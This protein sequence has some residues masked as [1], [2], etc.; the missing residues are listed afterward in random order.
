MG[1]S[2]DAKPRPHRR[3]PFRSSLWAVAAVLLLIAF[4]GVIGGTLL[5]YA[6]AAGAMFLFVL[7]LRE[8]L[9]RREV[10][11]NF[12]RQYGPTGKDLLVVYSDSPHWKEYI[13]TNW[14]PRWSARMVVLNR[15]KPWSDDQVEVKLWRQEAG[16]LEHTP[17]AILVPPKGS[18]TIVRFWLA[19]R[20]YKHGKDARLRDAEQRLR[21]ALG[22]Y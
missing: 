10:T 13:E 15:S 2:S 14:M 22:E 1:T 21:E 9:R 16:D 12:R 11:M 3:P 19:F 7:G 17:V 5:S 20:D 8:H 6:I 18:T 4:L